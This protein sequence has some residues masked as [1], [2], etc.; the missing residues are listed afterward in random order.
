MM[1]KIRNPS[2]KKAIRSLFMC[3]VPHSHITSHTHAAQLLVTG[4]ITT[5]RRAWAIARVTFVLNAA[6]TINE[7]VVDLAVANLDVHIPGLI[8]D[9]ISQR[10]TI[11]IYHS[12][13]S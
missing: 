12:P 13:V 5:T 11:L 3:P 6:I 2:V 9:G 8:T 1:E 7:L 10:I 4:E